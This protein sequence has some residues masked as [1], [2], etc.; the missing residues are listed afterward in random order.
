MEKLITLPPDIN[1]HW[2]AIAPLLTIRN[3]D[4]YEQAIQRLNNLIDEIGT[5][6]QHPLY[7][8]LDTLG[9]LIEA[10]EREHYSL[11]NCSG[12]DVLAYLMEEHKL[13]LS[14]LPE[15]GTSET[16][17]AILNKHQA[18]TPSQIQQLVQRFKVQ[19]QVFLD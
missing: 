9:T 18:L 6:E 10:Y 1:T 7:N 8:L 17:E 2:S 14:D 16:I 5:N 15:I 3:E 13:C 19:P 11:P 4:E 12:G